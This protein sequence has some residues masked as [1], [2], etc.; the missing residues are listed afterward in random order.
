VGHRAGLGA[1]AKKK[2]PPPETG[3]PARK[4]IIMLTEL[5]IDVESK[6]KNQNCDVCSWSRN[7]FNRATK[8]EHTWQKEVGHFVTLVV[9]VIVD[10]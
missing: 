3:R 6:F 10:V 2:S 1:V 8:K 9:H 5:H 4:A 7:C